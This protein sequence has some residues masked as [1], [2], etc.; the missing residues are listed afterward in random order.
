MTPDGFGKK[1]GED[2]RKSKTNLYGCVDLH[3]ENA[4]NVKAVREM[5]EHLC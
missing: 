3:P 4:R 1:N 5:W 2:E